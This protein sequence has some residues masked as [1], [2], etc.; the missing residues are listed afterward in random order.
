MKRV[1]IRPDLRTAGGEVCDILCGDRY[2]GTLTLVYREGKRMNGAVLLEEDKVKACGQEAVL[3]AIHQYVESLIEALHVAECE[4][5][6]S[7][8]ELD[9][10]IATEQNVGTVQRIITEPNEKR[11][12]RRSRY[13]LVVIGDEGDE[14][15]E[16]HIYE[17]SRKWIA[18][19]ILHCKNNKIRGEVIWRSHYPDKEEIAEVTDLIIDHL[20]TE[21]V[22]KISLDIKYGDESVETM[23]IMHGQPPYKVGKIKNPYKI[24]LVRDDG[25]VLTYDI[26]RS[27]ND[28]THIS[29]ASIDIT[30]SDVT[31]SVEMFE[32]VMKTTGKRSRHCCFSNWRRNGTTTRSICPL[33]TKTSRLTKSGSRPNGPNPNR[34]RRTRTSI[35]LVES[36]AAQPFWQMIFDHTFDFFPPSERMAVYTDGHPPV[37]HVE[38]PLI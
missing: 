27:G 7:I 13:E 24:T 8:G 36:K 12:K 35:E 5:I 32:K 29:R 28:R 10:V 6:V 17:G 9:R 16:Y 4:V 34:T 19:A 22:E 15:M 2:A 1:M 23:E 25:D 18:E 33:C 14:T 37:F 26:F 21:E 38:S 20:D 30:T 11:K 31:G 3:E